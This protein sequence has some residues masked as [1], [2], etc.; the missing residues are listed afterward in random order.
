MTETDYNNTAP[1]EL[2]RLAQQGD[3]KAYAAL[4]QAITPLLKSFVSKRLNSLADAEDVVQEI[5]MSIHRASH[6]YD[7]DRPFKVWMFT[8]ARYRLNDH[9]RKLYKKGAFP[10]INLEDMAQEISAGDVTEQQDKY[11]YLN[12]ALS[13]LPEK[14]KKIVTLMKIEGYSAIETAQAMNMSVSAVKVSAH[15]AYK[16]LALKV[17]EEDQ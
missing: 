15:R 12:K 11:E 14:Q 16:A 13:S 6:T 3:K 7:T 1:E 8:I 10:E 17:E 4:F 2:M 9:L 5:L